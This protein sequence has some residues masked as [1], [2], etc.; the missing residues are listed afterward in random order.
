MGGTALGWDSDCDFFMLLLARAPGSLLR[1]GVPV[2]LG[3]DVHVLSKD[4]NPGQSPV[5]G[6]VF[7][8]CL[9]TLVHRGVRTGLGC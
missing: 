8:Q 1:A 4:E 2:N 3:T 9:N 5:W 7:F 6:A